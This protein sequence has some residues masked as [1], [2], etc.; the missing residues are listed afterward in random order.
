MFMIKSSGTFYIK[1]GKSNLSWML[2]Y[3]YWENGKRFQKKV[4][5]L[6]YKELGFL[7]DYSIDDAKKRCKQLNAERSI[8]KDKIRKAVLNMGLTEPQMKEV[9]AWINA[10]DTIL[11]D[12]DIDQTIE[13][14]KKSYEKNT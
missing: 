10:E 3:Q 11:M 12:E 13:T 8:E 4:Q 14:I 2:Y 9:T 1:K 5:E 6:A 7:K